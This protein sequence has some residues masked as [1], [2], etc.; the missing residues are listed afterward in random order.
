VWRT[1]AY[2]LIKRLLA[3][4]KHRGSTRPVELIVRRQPRHALVDVVERLKVGH[5]ESQGFSGDVFLGAAHFIANSKSWQW[6]PKGSCDLPA[7][8]AGSKV[9]IV[10][11]PLVRHG[12][13]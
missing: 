11:A 5:R 10:A 9:L 6:T 8:L 4:R 1:A 13:P 2:R 12:A 3:K 7:S